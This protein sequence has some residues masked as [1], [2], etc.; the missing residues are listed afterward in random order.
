MTLYYSMMVANRQCA[1][2]NSIVRANELH[3]RGSNAFKL[4][5]YPPIS[6]FIA[7]QTLGCYT[8]KNASRPGRWYVTDLAGKRFYTFLEFVNL[9]SCGEGAEGGDCVLQV[10]HLGVCVV[11]VV[12]GAQVGVLIQHGLLGLYAVILNQ[13]GGNAQP[14]AVFEGADLAL[15]VGGELLG[16]GLG[17]ASLDVQLA[18]EDVGGAEGADAGLV[19]FHS[20]QI[21]N[22]GGLQKF[23]YFF[24][25][26]YPRLFDCLTHGCFSFMIH[27]EA[28]HVKQKP[29]EN[30]RDGTS[31]KM[32]LVQPK[33]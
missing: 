20:G 28:A 14:H 9:G 17:L 15:G 7:P 11:L 12:H 4:H 3:L 5:I 8:A 24:H 23:T 25:E 31:Q 16:H 13:L 1:D 33:K 6:L 29:K 10:Q 27:S 19:A 30:R 21:V 26:R 32:Q 22:T 18:L 2:A